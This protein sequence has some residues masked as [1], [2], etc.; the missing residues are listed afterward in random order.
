VKWGITRDEVKALFPESAPISVWTAEEE[1]LLPA[2]INRTELGLASFLV[3]GRKFSVAFFFDKDGVINGVRLIDRLTLVGPDGVDM[4]M[5]KCSGCANSVPTG[6]STRQSRQKADMQSF[7]ANAVKA[8]LTADYTKDNKDLLL[9]LL[10]EKYG[11]PTTHIAQPDGETENFD[12]V[13]PTTKIVTV[14]VVGKGRLQKPRR[15]FTL[16]L[17]FG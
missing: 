5:V 10:T 16:D 12:W 8:R 6:K 7:V 1:S 15:I 11:N 4:P 9:G 3:S 2:N 14:Q 13:F 17:A